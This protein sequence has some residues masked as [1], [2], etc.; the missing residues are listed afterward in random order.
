MADVLAQVP[1]GLPRD[2]NATA[3]QGTYNNFAS[4]HSTVVTGGTAVALAASFTQAKKLEILNPTSNADILVVGDSGVTVSPINGIPIEPGFSYPLGV[5]DLSK[6]YVN[7]ATNGA[8]FTYN[9]FW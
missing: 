4:G 7:S 6:V 1:N 3:I 5:T 9:Y 8:T 2:A